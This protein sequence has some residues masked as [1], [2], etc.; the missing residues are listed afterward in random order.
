MKLR[1]IK[2][3]GFKSFVDLTSLHL[4]SNLIG[5]VGPN[6]C[7]KSNI[8]DAVRWVMGEISAKQLRGESMHDVIFNGSSTRKPVGQA[9]AELVFDNSDASL[10][11][12]YAGYNEIAIRREVNRDGFSDYFLNN[13]TCRRKDIT[14]IFLGTGLGPDSYALIEQGTISKFIE[15]KTNELRVFIEEAAGISKYK[16][17]RRETE[18]R[19]K[20]TKENLFR[21]N[22]I[23]D[24]IDKQLKHLKSQANAAERYRKLK[25]EER[26]T[27]AEL[28]TLH[29]REINKKL[30]KQEAVIKNEEANL[31]NGITEFHVLS[32]KIAT[33]REEHNSVIEKFN[34]I[35][36]N[37]YRIGGNVAHLEQ[38]IEHTK[39]R[40]EQLT[41]DLAQIN[42]TWQE[43]LAHQ[44]ADKNRLELLTAEK[45]KI[46]SEIEEAETTLVQAKQKL[47]AAEER[48]KIW[49]KSWDNFNL[50]NSRILQALQVEE[51]KIGHLEANIASAINN[52]EKFK[53]EL[54]NLNFQA[55]HADINDINKLLQN[56][57]DKQEKFRTSGVEKK[58]QIVLAREAVTKLASTLDQTR[59]KLQTLIGR[60]SSLEALQQA[61]LGKN[62]PVL[63]AWLK[64][65]NLEQKSRL[66]QELQVVSGWETAVETVLGVYL[67]A[68]CVDDMTSIMPAV[69][70]LTRGNLV[71]LDKLSQVQQNHR[72]NL[73]TLAS[74]I[75]SPLSLGG[76]LSG[77]Y[78]TEDINEALEVR[79]QLNHEESIITRSGIWLGL[80]WLRVAYDVNPKI[81]IL[82]RE[83]ELQNLYAHITEIQN[84]CTK[85]EQ[86][87][88]NQQNILVVLEEEYQGLQH[89]L[90]DLMTEYSNAQSQVTAKK[91]NLQYVE[92]RVLVLK[93]EI[94]GE[95]N[96]LA[97][98]REQLARALQ[99]KDNTIKQKAIYGLKHQELVRDQ[100][101]IQQLL[102]AAREQ[103]QK[104]QENVTDFTLRRQ[105]LQTQLDYLIQNL[106]RVND[107]LTSLQERQLTIEKS[108]AEAKHPLDELAKELQLE[109]E[110]RLVEEN[111]LTEA[112]HKTARVE[113]ELRGLEQKHAAFQEAN[114]KIRILLEKARTEREGLQVRRTTYQEQIIELELKL[115]EVNAALPENAGISEWE[116]K[117]ATLSSRIER[118]GLVNL[119]AIDEFEKLKE[120]KNY[121]D[122]Q[123]QDLVSALNT[124][125]EVI[126]KIDHDTKE[127]FKEA[128]NNINLKFQDLF[129]KIFN[130][131]KAYLEQTADNLLET[132]ILIMAQPPGKKNSSIHLLSGGEKALTAIALIFAIFH[133]NPAPFC[134]LDEV[135]APLDDVNVLRFC[136]L[137][138]EMAKSIQFIFITHN[139]L[140]MEIASQ[141]IGVTMQEPGVSRIVTVD[142]DTTISLAES[143]KQ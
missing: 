126:R 95:E 111:N 17:R 15:A 127:R 133:L 140:T 54:A 125:E 64:Q 82:Q 38:Q 132:G 88:T 34:E 89:K 138:K 80:G 120:R 105:V 76:L 48:A 129:P 58:Q 74:K 23:L 39:E 51:T 42:Q 11:G 134:I 101:E 19:I 86:E 96:N 66:A 97:T 77:I 40:Q 50:D 49:Q 14:N 33:L 68:V 69:K 83:R 92:K 113:Q 32:A 123:N 79:A 10:G 102:E 61:A 57:Q 141:L 72:L 1:K 131:G 24:E 13:T 45:S 60:K 52:L 78:V 5:I 108:L 119:T 46:T 135:D 91:I 41:K 87:L 104:S 98:L 18:N 71:L 35:Q 137:V 53:T 20:N 12:E 31:E 114:E 28:H 81:G 112:K 124:L 93:Q 47:Q 43:A 73:A 130:G 9:V 26:L 56:L 37:Y 36:A 8:T 44:T 30:Q 55:L 99:D 29:W 85:E 4:Q 117:L 7:G 84:A 142:I 128:Y 110:Q 6:G 65:C 118:L 63:F 3:S 116:E 94:A 143:K 90:H 25:Q 67:E 122:A 136:T 16:E 21:F 59:N 107:R 109:L 22:D 2:L 100:D 27:K 139:K 115:E 75:N 103:A 106:N 62:D 70:N 121:L